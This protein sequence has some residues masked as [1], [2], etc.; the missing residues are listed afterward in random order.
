MQ[1]RGV[2]P[3][4]ERESR[5]SFET[6]DQHAVVGRRNGGH[7]RF[8]QRDHLNLDDRGG[9]RCTT[10]A[11][12]AGAA[13]A[14]ASSLQ[15]FDFDDSTIYR[16]TGVS[17]FISVGASRVVSHVVCRWAGITMIM[18]CLIMSL[19]RSVMGGAAKHHGVHGVTLDG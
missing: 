9:D 17:L 5:R 1:S 6:A 7:D 18:R 13:L 4:S 12:R 14:R 2:N 15:R 16:W 19:S 8:M 3:S 11:R 10:A